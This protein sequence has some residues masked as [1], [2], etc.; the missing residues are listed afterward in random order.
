MI[1]AV[2]RVEHGVEALAATLSALVPGVADGL[3][4][5]AVVLAATRDGPVAEVADALGASLIAG[6]DR[7]WGIGAQAAR[8]DW[9]LCLADGDVPM[10]GWIRTLDRFIAA[11]PADRG[12][13][14]L[15]RRPAALRDRLLRVLGSRDVR[16]GDLVRRDLLLRGGTGL[17]RPVR[18]SAVLGRDAVVRR[19]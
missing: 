4:G 7:S 15:A 10:E 8:R 13:G 2:V 16:A 3:V 14:R 11:S 1:S 19:A 9:I 18:V 17:G 12:F 6:A 5:D